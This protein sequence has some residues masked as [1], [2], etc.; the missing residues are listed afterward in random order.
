MQPYYYLILAF[1]LLIIILSVRFL[2][3]KKKN[4][5]VRLFSQALKTENSGHLE[6]AVITYESALVEVDKIRFH[7]DLKKKIVQKL[8]VLNTMIEYD[9]NCHFTR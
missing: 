8:K 1:A 5:P 9:K 6:E 4:I 3:L 2:I 7:S